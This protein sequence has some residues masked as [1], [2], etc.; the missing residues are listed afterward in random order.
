VLRVFRI[1]RILKL[2]KSA[3][4][5][6]ALLD[7]VM[8]SL[9]QVASIALLLLLLFFIYAC[10]AV[11]MFGVISCTDDNPCEG[12][13]AH[14]NF[15]NWAMA[16]LT[17]FRL[18]TGD[19]GSAILKDCM[20]VSPACD[21]GSTCADDCVGNNCNCCAQAPLA[22]V[23][24]YFITFTV[25]AQLIMLNVVVA[26]LMQSLDEAEQEQTEEEE[27]P[28][29]EE[30]KPAEITAGDAAAPPPSDS[31]NPTDIV[32]GVNKAAAVIPQQE[33]SLLPG[34]DLNSVKT[35]ESEMKVVDTAGQLQDTTSD[36]P[37]MIASQQS[38]V[39]QQTEGHQSGPTSLT[40]GPA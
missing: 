4:G 33:H 29:S 24:I 23:P 40:N 1:A 37:G 5:L 8:K 3:K 32:I 39:P 15:E 34:N 26:V 25:F 19:A 14:A 10:A 16:M 30:T 21:D 2:L 18:V 35:I 38:V 9:A 13:D 7:T 22:V 36:H 31:D 27:A 28:S 11:Q 17:L 12:L 20:R 6:K